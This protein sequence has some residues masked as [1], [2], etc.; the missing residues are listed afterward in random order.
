MRSAMLLMFGGRE[1]GG[2]GEQAPRGC[3]LAAAV[4][5]GTSDAGAARPSG[6]C[7]A[8]SRYMQVSASR[9]DRVLARTT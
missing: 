7:P 5:A 9:W 6:R 4:A 1:A 8:G 2:G 3:Q